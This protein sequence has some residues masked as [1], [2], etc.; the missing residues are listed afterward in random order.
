MKRATC[1]FKRHYFGKTDYRKRLALLKSGFPRAIVRT[2][3]KNI[4]VEIAEYSEKGD[5]IIAYGTGSTLAKKFNWK[6]SK[7][8]LS[9]CY[10]TGYYVGKKA[11]ITTCVLDTGLKTPT[12]GGKIFAVVKGFMDANVHINIGTRKTLNGKELSMLPTDE[13][14]NAGIENEIIRIKNEIEKNV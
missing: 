14:I 9:A 12:V 1:K 2:T 4:I 3:N 13:R 8:S 11:K 10:L 7:K 6:H 5:K